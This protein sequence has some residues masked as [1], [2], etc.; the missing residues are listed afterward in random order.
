VKETEFDENWNVVSR[1]SVIGK[2]KTPK[3]VRNIA[4]PD[5]VVAA[6]EEWSLF[7]KEQKISS[8]YVFP[9]TKTGGFRKYSGLRSS[10]VRFVAK[11][12][13][14]DEKITLYTFRHTFATILLEEREN[15]KIVADMMGHT[16][17]STTLDLYSHVSR[18]AVSSKKTT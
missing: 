13:L 9:N 11:H 15:P 6:I 1:T 8:E 14:E 18:R 4:L 2:T 16:R 12:K 17:V 7:C 5:A 3:S 10:L